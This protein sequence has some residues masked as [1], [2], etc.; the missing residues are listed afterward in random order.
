MRL[1]TRVGWVLIAIAVI[2]SVWVI[3][4]DE[5]EA[6]N[7]V[8]EDG[9]TLN[10]AGTEVLSYNGNGG[11]VT[12]PAGVSTID[13]GVF[14]NQTNIT[15]VSMPDTVYNLG[16]GV[17]SGC[18]GLSSVSLSGNLSSIPSNTF[19]GCSSLGS[20]SIP[21]SVTSIGSGAFQ[22]C[23][24]ISTISIPARTSSVDSG[25]FDD[26]PNLTAINVAG[27]N[28]SYSS[29]DGCLY[30]ANGS[31][32]I[33]CPE[34]K[35]TVNISP[36]CTS[37]GGGALRDCTSVD[38]I[39][40]PKKVTSISG[41]AFS[42]SSLKTIYGYSDSTAENFAST[43]GYSF[44]Q[45]DNNSSGSTAPS[46]SSSSSSE[47]EDDD[48]IDD[49]DDEDDEEG[50]EDDDSS[51]DDDDSGSGGSGSGSGEGGSGGSGG[52]SGGGGSTSGGPSG[53]GGHNKDATPKTAD[54]DVDPRF[55]FS[56]ALLLAGGA[57]IIFSERRRIE[58]ITSHRR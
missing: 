29:Y 21:S 25:A 6:N 58:Y 33:R 10:E 5:N 44:I 38:S 52:G 56:L 9:F 15:S 32:L 40:I 14:S 57:F 46:S 3:S 26:C 35:A 50:D 2:L 19:N 34:N 45:L 48:D 27:G 49:E 42:S 55:M 13:S 36:N 54:G 22:G 23:S 47:D 37:I 18:T 16:T 4:A 12:I 20:I 28:S 30:N 1:G 17:F 41:D 43:Y 24:G 51:D 53:S 11:A 39:T 8:T 31:N 7:Q